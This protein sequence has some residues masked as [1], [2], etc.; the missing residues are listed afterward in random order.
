M[1]QEYFRHHQLCDC[2]I[3]TEEWE[4][5]L[6]AISVGKYS[7]ACVLMLH[8]AGYNP[9][10]YIPYRTYIRLIKN[11]SIPNTIKTRKLHNMGVKFVAIKTEVIELD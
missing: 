2:T 5:I 6:Q 11:N 9:L 7:W 1:T 8:T 10:T 4:A 3:L